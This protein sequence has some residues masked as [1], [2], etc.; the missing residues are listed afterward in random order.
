MANQGFEKKK[1]FLKRVLFILISLTVVVFFW[2]V[3]EGY[4]RLLAE[5]EIKK[6]EILVRTINPEL[7]IEVLDKIIGLK[8]FSI[9]E[10]DKELVKQIPILTQAPTSTPSGLNLP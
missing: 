9:E 6:A 4:H 1:E 2:L 3:Q 10:V 5:E 7:K 8:Q